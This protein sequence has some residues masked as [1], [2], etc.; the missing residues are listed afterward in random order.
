MISLFLASFSICHTAARSIWVWFLVLGH[1]C[2]CLDAVYCNYTVTFLGVYY[3]MWQV[4]LHCTL[5]VQQLPILVIQVHPKHLRLSV[6]LLFSP[7]PPVAVFW[8]FTWSLLRHLFSPLIALMFLQ[9]LYSSFSYCSVLV[10]S[11]F[12][13]D[14]PTGILK[15]FSCVHRRARF[16]DKFNSSRFSKLPQKLTS[17]CLTAKTLLTLMLCTEAEQYT[18]TEPSCQ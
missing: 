3:S 12:H 17:E 2:V 13:S 14:L 4:L 1:C 10:C 18:S 5:Y 9:Q 8:E 11:Y 6:S 15:S 7:L 16:K